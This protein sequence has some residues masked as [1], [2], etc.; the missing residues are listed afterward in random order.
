METTEQ[1]DAKFK[2]IDDLTTTNNAIPPEENYEDFARR[3]REFNAN[4][5]AIKLEIIELLKQNPFY[6]RLFQMKAF[7][8]LF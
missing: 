6:K 7:G 8:I 1:I 2:L 5:H 4:V 3:N